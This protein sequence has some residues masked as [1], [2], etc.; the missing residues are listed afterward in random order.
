MTTGTSF[1]TGLDVIA[2]PQPTDLMSTVGHAEQHQIADSA[3]MAIE[4]TIGIQGSTVTGTIEY[5][6]FSTS[7]TSP[8]HRHHVSEI[9]DLSA[10]PTGATGPTGLPSFITGPT[11]SLGPYGPTGPVGMQGVT[12]PTG[13]TGPIGT[14]PT[15]AT[16]MASTVTGPTGIVGATGATGAAYIVNTT[17]LAPSGSTY[18]P[19]RTT[20]YNIAIVNSP[21]SAFSIGNLASGT[22]VNGDILMLRIISG[23]N[24]YSISWGSGYIGSGIATLPSAGVANKTITCGFQYDSTKGRWVLLAVDNIGY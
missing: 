4:Q 18:S 1:P 22:P 6:L 2:L 9:V 10:G 14:G 11:G 16:G 8:G 5:G 23:S 21:T 7:S 17:T 19:S 20:N 24:A 13:W 15:G 12:G 3:I